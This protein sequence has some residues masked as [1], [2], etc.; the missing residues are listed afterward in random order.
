MK[1]NISPFGLLRTLE[2][3]SVQLVQLVLLSSP[4][5]EFRQPWFTN[6]LSNM[7]HSS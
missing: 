5:I 6:V 7:M 1:G 4:A 2:L 3:L